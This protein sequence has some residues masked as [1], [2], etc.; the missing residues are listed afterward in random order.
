MSGIISTPYRKLF[1]TAWSCSEFRN[2]FLG[3]ALVAITFALAGDARPAAGAGVLLIVW[4]FIVPYIWIDPAGLEARRRWTLLALALTCAIL[5][6]VI[7]LLSLAAG[8]MSAMVALVALAA[9][10]ILGWVGA[11]RG[12]GG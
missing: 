4:A 11:Q 10:W 8:V 6:N 9:G 7:G 1:R 2:V 5:I 12:T 3:L